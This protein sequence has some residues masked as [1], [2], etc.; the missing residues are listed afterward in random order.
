MKTTTGSNAPAWLLE[1]VELKERVLARLAEM[2]EALRENP[3]SKDAWSATEVVEHLILV[4]EQVTG[5]WRKALGSSPAVLGFKSGVLAAMVS[6]AFAR[7]GVR[8]PTVPELVPRGDLALPQLTVRWG[9]AREELAAAVP[10]NSKVAW[11]AHPVFGPLSSDQVGKIF[12][13]HL[14]HYLRH[15][16][17]VS[18]QMR[19]GNSG[20]HFYGG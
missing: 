13:A 1:F 18:L 7:T 9:K 3:P 5:L 11:I 6:A 12:L 10:E 8:V 20:E 4:E 2:P 14:K 15:W 17:Q 16:R 19:K